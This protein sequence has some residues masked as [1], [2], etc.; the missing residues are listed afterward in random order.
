MEL[1]RQFEIITIFQILSFIFLSLRVNADDG[2][3]DSETTARRGLTDT[4][5]VT[6]DVSKYGARGDG[7]SDS[8]QVSL[9]EV[10][11][12]SINSMYKLKYLIYFNEML[13]IYLKE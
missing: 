4:G 3:F 10:N 7:R 8:T 9:K 2:S 1:K 12:F 13:R 5:A 11:V 6:F